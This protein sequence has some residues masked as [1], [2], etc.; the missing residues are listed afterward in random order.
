[1]DSTTEWTICRHARARASELGF[2]LI[3]L[4]V[5]AAEPEQSYEQSRYGPGRWMHQRGDVAV[6]VN[7]QTRT[8]ITV[9]LRRP[10][11]WSHGVHR[12]TA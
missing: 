7:R 11:Q 9:V 6:A 2:A 3:D 12:R 4:L 8:I 10:D 5:A 1:M